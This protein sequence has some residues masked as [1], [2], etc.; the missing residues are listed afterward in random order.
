MGSESH[1]R[2]R[3]G[4]GIAMGG[5][6]EQHWSF[7]SKPAAS[8]AAWTKL[9]QPTHD[10]SLT[11]LSPAHHPDGQQG[12]RYS[13]SCIAFGVTDT[14]LCDTPRQMRPEDPMAVAA[15]PSCQPAS[16]S[17]RVP[18]VCLCVY[19]CTD[20]APVGEGLKHCEGWGGRQVGGRKVR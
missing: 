3:G 5:S 17:P 12:P 4:F 10:W 13:R 11:P 7:S 8:L 20:I 15:G 19:V 14:P 16:K 9:E 2:S 1:H 18:D 6:L